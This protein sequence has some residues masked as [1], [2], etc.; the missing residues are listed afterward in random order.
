[1]DVKEKFKDFNQCFLSLIN[2][3]PKTSRPTNDVT[4]EFYMSTLPPNMAM[5]VKRMEKTTLYENFQARVKVEKD[6]LSVHGKSKMDEDKSGTSKK[7]KKHGK[8]TSDKK[9][10]DYFNL[11]SMSKVITRLA[12][13]MAYLKKMSLENAHRGYNKPTFKNYNPNTIKMGMPLE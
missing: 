11:Q 7:K 2:R 10:Y 12:N 9:E 8:S 6:L 13:D 5:F 4:I 1:M 3:I